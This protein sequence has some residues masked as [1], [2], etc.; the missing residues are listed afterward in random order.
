MKKNT[1]ECLKFKISIRIQH[2]T[3]SPSANVECPRSPPVFC[4]SFQNNIFNHII[5]KDRNWNQNRNYIN[6]F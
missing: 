2:L 6:Q 5:I 3:Y 1:N 4:D